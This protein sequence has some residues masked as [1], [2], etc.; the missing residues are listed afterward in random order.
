M[1]VILEMSITGPET[2][3]LNLFIA[4]VVSAESSIPGPFIV[5][6]IS[7]LNHIR[8]VSSSFQ[9]ALLMLLCLICSVSL[10]LFIFLS[11]SSPILNLL[12]PLMAC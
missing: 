10:E 5:L 11:R 3:F 9:N 12:I 2:S 8:L 7:F 4:G 6:N 1:L